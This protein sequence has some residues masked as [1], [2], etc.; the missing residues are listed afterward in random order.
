MCSSSLH[1]ACT[2]LHQQ[3]AIVSML[4]GILW[5]HLRRKAHRLARWQ[6]C[7]AQRVLPS[8]DL[9]MCPSD[10]VSC[11]PP[12]NFCTRC[13]PATGATFNVCSSGPHTAPSRLRQ[14]HLS[15]SAVG[16]YR[17]VPFPL[18][19]PPVYQ[20]AVQRWSSEVQCLGPSE[21]LMIHPELV[22]CGCC[23]TSAQHADLQLQTSCTCTAITMCSSHLVQQLLSHWVPHNASVAGQC[24][25]GWEVTCGAATQGKPH[26]LACW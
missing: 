5:C 14:Y 2:T 13:T 6:C 10:S 26:W 8:D 24:F 22:P 19:P 1:A 25:C 18:Q 16:Q 3:Q 11:F 17:V 21:S 15:V 7:V 4:G 12:I 23:S 9:T 20:L